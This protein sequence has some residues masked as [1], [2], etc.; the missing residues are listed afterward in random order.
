MPRSHHVCQRKEKRGENADP[1]YRNP[2]FLHR[3]KECD[4]FAHGTLYSQGKKRTIMNWS[5]E[6]RRRFGARMTQIKRGGLLGRLGIKYVSLAIRQS[7]S[8]SRQPRSCIAY[9]NRVWIIGGGKAKALVNIAVCRMMMGCKHVGAV[10]VAA[11]M[12]V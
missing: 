11:F 5:P 9:G 7:P 12:E 6:R 4:S 10:L 8:V 3:F 2:I 1:R